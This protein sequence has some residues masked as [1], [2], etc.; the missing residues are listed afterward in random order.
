MQREDGWVL[1]TAMGLMAIML[2]VIFATM[3]YVDN[4]QKQS[5]LTRTRET[6]FNVAEAALNAQTFALAK[7]WPGT[8]KAN[9]QYPICTPNSTSLRCPSPAYMQSLFTG[10][11]ARGG[12][13]WTTQVRDN[14]ASGTATV[15]EVRA[16]DRLGVLYR[17]TR[18]M[19]DLDLDLGLAKVSTMGAEVVDSFYV[20]TANGT[21]VADRDLQREVQR[22]LLHALTSL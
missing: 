2:S 10:V 8:G 13:T 20:R 1:I 16:P 21:K 6:A 17:I 11:D 5:R 19:A 14:N 15:V 4:E 12:I 18:A 7:E 9:D 3:N 22:A